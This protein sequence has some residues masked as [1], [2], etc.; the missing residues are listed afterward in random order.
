MQGWN[1]YIYNKSVAA[2][3]VTHTCAHDQFIQHM[4]L[5]GCP[6]KRAASSGQAEPT[7][8]G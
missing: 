1:S 3:A 8:V 5:Q 7:F 4:H 6:V 2:G